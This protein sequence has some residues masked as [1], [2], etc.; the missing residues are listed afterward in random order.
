MRTALEGVKKRLVASIVTIEVRGM[1]P[2]RPV[3]YDTVHFL[4]Y[5]IS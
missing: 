4:I 2:K 5:A 1:S 3:W